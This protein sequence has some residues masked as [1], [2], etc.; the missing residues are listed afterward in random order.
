MPPADYKLVYNGKDRSCY[1]FCMCP[2]GYVVNA[3]SEDERL[4]VNGMSDYKRDAENA[5]SALVV[6][7][8]PEDFETNS[9]LAGIEFQ[10]KY[11]SMAFKLGGSDFSAPVQLAKDF[12]AGKKSSQLESVNPSFTGKTVLS[13]LRSCLPEFIS[14]TLSED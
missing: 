14:D 4:V 13:D 6:S 12:L 10:R 7:V 8:R 9:P 5:N 1:S 3:S 2:G 11:E